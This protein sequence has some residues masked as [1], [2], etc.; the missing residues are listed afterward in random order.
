MKITIKNL[1]IEI[2]PEEIKYLQIDRQI[3]KMANEI[4]RE[5]K[6]TAEDIKR[7]DKE[8]KETEE[9]IKNERKKIGF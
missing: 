1:E 7:I 9:Y 3:D 4:K 2:S 5:N 6:K 8:I